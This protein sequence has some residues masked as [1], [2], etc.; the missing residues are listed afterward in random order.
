M[1]RTSSMN[2]R[3]RFLNFVFAALIYNLWRLTDYLIK[4]GLK[5]P[6]RSEVV[7]G[8]G[9]SLAWSGIIFVG[10]DDYRF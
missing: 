1:P 7:L 3:M 5:M 10:L 6:I 4:R 9:H 8:A 2:F